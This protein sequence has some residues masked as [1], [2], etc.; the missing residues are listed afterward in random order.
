MLLSKLTPN[1]ISPQ[2]P[3][4]A[5]VHAPRPLCL[6]TISPVESDDTHADI[7][8]AGASGASARF[9]RRGET[10][11]RRW[12]RSVHQPAAVGPAASLKHKR[13]PL[14]PFLLDSRLHFHCC[15]FQIVLMIRE[16][17]GMLITRDVQPPTVLNPSAGSSGDISHR[18]WSGIKRG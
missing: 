12:G 11:R 10:R 3:L 14:R 2:V 8:A 9:P 13:F 17:L 16:I 15:A 5:T 18:S 1:C 7:A 4:Q 6:L